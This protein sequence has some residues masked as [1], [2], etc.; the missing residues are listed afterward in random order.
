MNLVSGLNSDATYA[1][2]LSGINSDLSFAKL[3]TILSISMHGLCT[4]NVLRR[5]ILAAF[6]NVP[7][8]AD[9]IPDFS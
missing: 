3:R 9:N 6:T 8:K 2:A 7:S 4:G 1:F 5:P